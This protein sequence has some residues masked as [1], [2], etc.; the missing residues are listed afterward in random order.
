MVTPALVSEPLR[1]SM[2]TRPGHWPDQLARVRMGPL[3]VVRPARTWWEYCQTA[4]AT[5]SGAFSGMDL[6]DFHAVLLG[7]DEAVAVAVGGVGAFD[8][9]TDFFECGGDELFHCELCGLA[10][11]V[12]GEAEVAGGDEVDGFSFGFSFC[13]GHP[14][15]PF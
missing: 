14:W 7:V 13:F 6:E 1:L 10:F 11:L 15:G 9:G 3:W 8:G 5:T 2:P 4:S 12:G